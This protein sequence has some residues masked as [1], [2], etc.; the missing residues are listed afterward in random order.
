MK[1]LLF[2]AALLTVGFVA[3]DTPQPTTT[4]P[5]DSSSINSNKT[6]DTSAT[7]TDTSRTQ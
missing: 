7:K 2:I 6:T 4:D 1:N 5:S 3:C